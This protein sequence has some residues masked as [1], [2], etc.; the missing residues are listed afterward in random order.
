[1]NPIS[2]MAQTVLRRYPVAMF[3]FYNIRK[4][5]GPTSHDVVA[6]MRRRLPRKTRV[7]HA[8][9]LDPFASGV[10]VVAIGS[11]TRLIEYLHRRPKTYVAGIRLHA[12]SDTDDSQGHITPVTDPP[13]TAP[14]A[15][16]EALDAFRGEIEQVPPAHSAAKVNG[17][18]AY[19]L[20]RQGREVKLAPRRVKIHRLELLDFAPPRA[21]LEIECS[22]GT[23]IRSLARDL[24]RALGS[25]AYCDQLE[26]TAV[27]P[28]DISRARR[29]ED[30]D[31]Q[32]DLVDPLQAVDDLPLR[33]VTDAEAAELAQG[34]RIANATGLDA[35][36]I[37][38]THGGRLL[39]L[40]TPAGAHLLQPTKV[41]HHS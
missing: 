9:T 15:L 27:G 12:A 26:R 25:A 14:H 11:A 1:M 5:T 17:R 41:F 21:T 39:A 4:P 18:R 29:V 28:F 32:A 19:K 20:A 16:A 34:K 3:G 24:G 2:G 40:L 36:E 31:L 7:G 35:G 37:A 30:V 6:A 10:L 13:E 22:T 33:E 38:A 8:G 23:Y